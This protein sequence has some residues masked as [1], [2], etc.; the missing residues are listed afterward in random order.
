MSFDKLRLSMS[1]NERMLSKSTDANGVELRK[2]GAYN[3][4]APCASIKACCADIKGDKTSARVT[5]V[6]GRFANGSS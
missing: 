3:D 6:V 1:I 5:G 4:P 2:Y